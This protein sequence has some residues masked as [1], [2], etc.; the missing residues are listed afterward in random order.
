MDYLCDV[1]NDAKTTE[2]EQNLSQYHDSLELE[3]V[4]KEEAENSTGVSCA[5]GMACGRRLTTWQMG[6]WE[7]IEDQQGDTVCL[8][9]MD[10]DIRS[11]TRSKAPSVFRYSLIQLDQ[12][13]L[14]YDDMLGYGWV[15]LSVV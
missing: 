11:R 8:K 3:H 10:K 13:L 6:R 4:Y 2:W 9:A 7:E 1:G 12:H 14:M 15:R 5:N